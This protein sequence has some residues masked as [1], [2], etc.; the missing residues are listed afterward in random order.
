MARPHP[1][2]KLEALAY[3][4]LGEPEASA[5]QAHVA[6]CATCQALVADA[7]AIRERLALLRNDEPRIDVLEQVL[8]DI[9]IN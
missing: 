8:R 5:V 2:E 9:D 4:W 3:G 1:L 7:E 6:H